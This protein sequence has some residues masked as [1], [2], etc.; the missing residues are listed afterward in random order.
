MAGQTSDTF[1]LD[2]GADGWRHKIGDKPVIRGSLIMV[3]VDGEWI[4]GRYE[5]DD[6]SPDAREDACAVTHCAAD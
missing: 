6:L 5:S 2:R 4:G 1:R 3:C